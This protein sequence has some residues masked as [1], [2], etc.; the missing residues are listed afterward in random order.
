M[1][2]FSSNWDLLKPLANHDLSK[3]SKRAK[4]VTLAPALNLFLY[5]VE[6]CPNFSQFDQSTSPLFF[7]SS[8]GLC[9]KYLQMDEMAWY[10]FRIKS[11]DRNGACGR[12]FAQI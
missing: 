9:R 7:Q 5:G 8:S 11:R 12:G 4:N 3:A 2:G 1:N 10:E 6:F